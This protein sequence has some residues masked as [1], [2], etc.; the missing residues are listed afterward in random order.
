[1]GKSAFFKAV[2]LVILPFL[3]SCEPE[4]LLSIDQ[5]SITIPSSGGS[6]EVSLTANKPWTASS[7]KSWC[8]ISPSSGENASNA[9][10]TITCEANTTYEERVCTVLFSCA[11]MSG[12]VQVKQEANLGLFVSPS[13]YEITNAAQQVNIEVKTNVKFTVEVDGRCKDWITHSITK[14]L[15]SSIVVLDIKENNDYDP[16]EGIITIKE[17]NGTLSQ[18]ITIKQSQTDEIILSESVLDVS[19]QS[20]TAFIA[21]KAN[22]DFTVNPQVEWINYLETKGLNESQIQLAIAENNSEEDRVGIVLIKQVNGSLQRELV[23]NQ[24]VKDTIIVSGADDT[25]INSNSS[26]IDFQIR[27][28]QQYSIDLGDCDWIKMVNTK[29]LSRYN[30]TLI[31]DKN[32][33]DKYRS[34]KVAIIKE[35][36]SVYH[37]FTITQRANERKYVLYTFDVWQTSPINILAYDSS[38]EFDLSS[39]ERMYIDDI[40]VSPT[41][42]YSFPSV[43]EHT[44]WVLFKNLAIPRRASIQC[45]SLTRAIIGDDITFIGSECFYFC[46]QLKQLYIG[47]GVSFIGKFVLPN[48]HPDLSI[49]VSPNNPY[50]DSRDNCN[51]IIETRTSKIIASSGNTVIPNTVVTIGESSFWQTK[52]LSS[53]TIPASVKNIEFQS[54]MYTDLKSI[55]FES[56]DIKIAERAII[57]NEELESIY[58]PKDIASDDHKCLIKDGV[59]LSFAAKGITQYT[60]PEGVTRIGGQVFERTTALHSILLPNTLVSI[61][62]L[63]FWE[64]G[65]TAI[66]IPDSVHTIE[67]QAFTLCNKLTRFVF[68]RG[69]ST[70]QLYTLQSCASLKEIYSRATTAPVLSTYGNVFESIPEGGTLYI[71]KGSDYSEWMKDEPGCLGYYHWK[72]I[73]Q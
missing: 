58:G 51:A 24:A 5:Y 31:V 20:Q 2:L 18:S 40:E 10:I 11:E 73:E 27:T 19:G 44:V 28:N 14:G 62:A 32:D 29:S 6:G 34:C 47:E 67:L 38:N 15:A 4:T 71:P 41:L 9:R 50:Y 7:D 35:N 36:G 70:L 45:T 49:E 60:I 39:V 48:C 54:I 53:I 22:T 30:E 17:N 65:I 68:G 16:R 43:G 57:R 72:V 13:I 52:G 1:M 56:A 55:T 37:S 63:A 69:L 12:T 59:L 8:M 26:Q 64:S 66:E 25:I 46:R 42:T 21:I 3:Y 33:S 23:I 61:A